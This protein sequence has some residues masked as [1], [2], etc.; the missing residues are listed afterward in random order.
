LFLG[1]VGLPAGLTHMRLEDDGLLPI[2][3]FGESKSKIESEGFGLTVHGRRFG[4]V[5]MPFRIGQWIERRPID[6]RPVFDRMGFM[7]TGRY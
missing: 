2:E 6:V 1:S 4:M 3:A 5:V 7:A